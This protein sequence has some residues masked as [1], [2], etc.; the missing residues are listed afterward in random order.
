MLRHKSSR[1]RRFYQYRD[2][3]RAEEQKMRDRRKRTDGGWVKGWLPST[4]SG[5]PE[6]EELMAPGRQGAGRWRHTETGQL[7]GTARGF[8][9]AAHGTGRGSPPPGWL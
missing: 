7:Q 1:G 6:R 2:R 9:W 3:G 4:W 5:D 8:G